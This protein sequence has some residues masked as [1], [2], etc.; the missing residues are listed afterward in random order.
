MQRAHDQVPQVSTKEQER[1]HAL[2]RNDKGL[3]GLPDGQASRLG[4]SVK[5]CRGAN[6][7]EQGPDGEGFLD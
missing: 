7:Q 1:Q 4:E 6:V 5:A 3:F 2:P